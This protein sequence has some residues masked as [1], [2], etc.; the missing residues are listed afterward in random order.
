MDAFM[1]QGASDPIAVQALDKLLM[2]MLEQLVRAYGREYVAGL[3]DPLVPVDRRLVARLLVEAL[4]LEHGFRS[5]DL[6]RGPS[7]LR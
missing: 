5:D 4:A 3:F 1:A 7:P 2:V 6:D